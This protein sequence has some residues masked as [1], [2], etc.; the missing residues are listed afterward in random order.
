MAIVMP[1][2]AL[3]PM[4]HVELDNSLGAKVGDVVAIELHGKSVLK[5]SL[6]MYGV[7]CAAFIA[8]V[9]LGSIWGD[10]YTAV[11]GVVFAAGAFFIIKGLE[12][13]FSKMNEFKPRMVEILDS[14]EEE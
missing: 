4:K 6:I 14:R 10:L 8:G 5:A 11:A 2:S 3:A 7:P 12:P 9:A 1:V 13:R